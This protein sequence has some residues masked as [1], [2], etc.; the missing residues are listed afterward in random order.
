MRFLSSEEQAAI[1]ASISAATSLYPVSSTELS[2]RYGTNR[3]MIRQI[4][5]RL[6]IQ[7]TPIASDQ[8]GYWLARTPGELH[9]T[10][11]HLR[12]RATKIWA[13]Y[14]GLH[15]AVARMTQTDLLTSDP[16]LD[17][18]IQTERELA[19]SRPPPKADG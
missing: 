8:N 14:Q 16:Q 18:D 10:L 1:A 3:P 2:A 11:R 5:H 9:G 17:L 15:R 12:S 4:V 13:A 7:G 6:R 19:T